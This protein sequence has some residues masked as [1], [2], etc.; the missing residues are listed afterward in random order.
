MEKLS[1][2]HYRRD[3]DGLRGL[4]ILCVVLF[5]A[6]GSLEGGFIGV[7]V[8][9]VISGYLITSILLRELR[10]S[11][12]IS[13]AAFWERRIR[14][15]LPASFVMAIATL[16]LGSIILLPEDLLGLAKSL[17][18]HAVTLSN[19]HFWKDSGYFDGAAEEKPLLHTWSLSVEEQFY[20]LYPLLFVIAG[21]FLKNRRDSLAPDILLLPFLIAGTIS[22]L[23]LSTWMVKKEASMAFY[24]LPSRFWEMLL[25][26]VLA[27]LPAS[28]MSVSQLWSRLAAVAGLGLILG[29]ALQLR[30][31]MPFP[32]WLAL[33]A[34]LGAAFLIWSLSPEQ[35]GTRHF[36]VRRMM[37]SR[38]LVGLGLVSYSLYLWHWPLLALWD[39]VNAGFSKR[40]DDIVRLVMVLLAIGISYASW[41]WIEIPFRRSTALLPRRR[42][43]ASAIVGV[44]LLVGTGRW[45][46]LEGG[47]PSRWTQEQMRLAAAED[48]MGV[49]N[50]NSEHLFESIKL[51]KLPRFGSPNLDA[52]LGVLV[53]GDSHA[54][55]LSPAIAEQATQHGKAGFLAWY[56]STPPGLGFVQ[57]STSG[58]GPRAV[59]WGEAILKIVKDQKIP[60]VVL[61]G[62]WRR[63]AK[64]RLEELRLSL[65]QT[66]KRFREEAGAQV[67]LVRDVPSHDI[68]VP[69]A[70]ALHARVP[71]FFPNA[72][73]SACTQEKHEQAN[74]VYHALFDELSQSCG[75]RILDPASA[76][77]DE[78]G[79]YRLKHN[80]ESLY[81]DVGHHLSI[82]G[83]LH[84]SPVFR[85]IFDDAPPLR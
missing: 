44:A 62:Y 59:E 72:D 37:E 19:F 22:G 65:E 3:V 77:A 43:F 7:D 52:P 47:F 24:L 66:V 38:L 67:W 25:G 83:A 64:G 51:G 30:D 2:T 27:C 32:G 28:W 35:A 79:R 39:Y 68:M 5:H 61:V 18:A 81:G 85:P 71:W 26:G 60:N 33:P 54:W 76:L 45:I 14:R 21:H 8:F 50:S 46:D 6:T 16:F 15:I 11:G 29:S 49:P 10:Q 82:A 69:R 42:V 1:P 80:G 84:V 74:A 36:W 34:C 56:P 78:N 31:T 9:F 20:I 73:L 58:L 55:C 4:S 63:V 57:P 48:Q 17:T 12:Q 40:T 23:W 70:L 53:W 41:R 13:L 75:L